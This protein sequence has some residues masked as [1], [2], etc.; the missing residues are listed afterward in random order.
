VYIV[1]MLDGHG[2]HQCAEYARTRLGD[3]V[4]EYLQTARG[5]DAEDVCRNPP[6]YPP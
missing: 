3:Y 1:G 5:D 4:V 2:G 6:P